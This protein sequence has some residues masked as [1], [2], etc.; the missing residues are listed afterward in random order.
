M[1]WRQSSYACVNDTSVLT[2]DFALQDPQIDSTLLVLSNEMLYD[3]F[4]S[5]K[6]GLPEQGVRKINELEQLR[7]N[8]GSTVAKDFLTF[9]ISRLY[10]FGFCW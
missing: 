2:L 1:L 4:N 7:N 3:A 10:A 6:N 9:H 5:F 8:F